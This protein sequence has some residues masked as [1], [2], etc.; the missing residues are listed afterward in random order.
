MG[1]RLY[2]FQKLDE[3]LIV[4][5]SRNANCVVVTQWGV[6]IGLNIFGVVKSNKLYVII[7][8]R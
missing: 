4:K 2:E 5:I 6:I 3:K 1:I 7:Y 8:H